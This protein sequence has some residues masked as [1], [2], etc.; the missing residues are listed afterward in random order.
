LPEEFQTPVAV[1]VHLLDPAVVATPITPAESEAKEAEVKEEPQNNQDTGANVSRIPV[2]S[3]GTVVFDRTTLPVGVSTDV[4][5]VRFSRNDDSSGEGRRTVGFSWV[6][7][8]PII[9]LFYEG[10][11]PHEWVDDGSGGP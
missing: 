1:A 4:I 3:S 7:S 10:E 5:D 2:I 6:V 9:A 8:K 11:H